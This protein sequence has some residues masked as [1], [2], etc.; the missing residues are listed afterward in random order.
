MKPERVAPLLFA[1]LAAVYWISLWTGGFP[2]DWAVKAAPMLLAA[3]VLGQTLPARLGLPMAIGFI[4]A[5][6]G[7]VFLALDRR[8]YLMQ[9]LLCFLV[10]QLAY[11]TAF[12]ARQR[13]PDDRLEFRLPVAV[14]GLVVLAMMLPAL[15]TF[16]WPV[17]LYVVALITMAVLAA[18]FEAGPGRVFAGACVFVVADSLIGIDRFVVPVPFSEPIIV[19]LY[20]IGQFLIFTGMLTVRSGMGGPEGRSWLAND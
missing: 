2:G 4:A 9:G 6:A 19:G 16:F 3:A 13:P 12:L 15:D 11:S 1:V 8:E 17:T 7:D 14:Y 18:G 10:T 20:A 5:A